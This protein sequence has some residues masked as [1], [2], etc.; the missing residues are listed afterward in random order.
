M[1]RNIARFGHL[2]IFEHD[3]WCTT[4]VYVPASQVTLQMYNQYVAV[5]S[6]HDLWRSHYDTQVEAQLAFKEFLSCIHPQSTRRRADFDAVMH[7]AIAVATAE[8]RAAAD[9]PDI[10]KLR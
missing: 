1:F 6:V 8:N 9:M 3:A 7:E 10:P 4:K 5:S 2:L